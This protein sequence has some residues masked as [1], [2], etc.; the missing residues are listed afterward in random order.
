MKPKVSWGGVVC[1]GAKAPAGIGGFG[2]RAASSDAACQGGIKGGYREFKRISRKGLVGRG[3]F[4]PPISWSQTRRFSGLS[5]RPPAIEH[6]RSG[7]NPARVRGTRGHVGKTV[8]AHRPDPRCLLDLAAAVTRPASCTV[9]I[10][11]SGQD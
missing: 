3:G 5:H 4:E 9:L 10:G 7:G 2:L 11:G 1:L 8:K 6:T